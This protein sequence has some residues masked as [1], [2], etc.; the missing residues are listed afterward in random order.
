[1]IQR[2]NPN[3]YTFYIEIDVTGLPIENP[4]NNIYFHRSEMPLC[5]IGRINSLGPVSKQKKE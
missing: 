5:V 4:D 3:K 1:M 2:P